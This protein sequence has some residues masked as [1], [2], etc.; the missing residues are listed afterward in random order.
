VA[1]VKKSKSGLFLTPGTPNDSELLGVRLPRTL[2]CSGPTG[3]AVL[4]AGGRLS[5][6]QVAE[7]ALSPVQSS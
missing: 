2:L 7:A 6:V 5:A 4:V 1:E 3:R